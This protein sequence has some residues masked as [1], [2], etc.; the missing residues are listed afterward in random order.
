MQGYEA[1]LHL[2]CGSPEL[3]VWDPNFVNT[4]HPVLGWNR[5]D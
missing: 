4:P 5:F 3:T 2:L 1:A